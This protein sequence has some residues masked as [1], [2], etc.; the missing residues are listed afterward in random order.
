[1]SSLTTTPTQKNIVERPRLRG[2]MLEPG[3]PPLKNIRQSASHH[4]FY[5]A[6]QRNENASGEVLR[7]PGM[8]SDP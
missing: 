2:L 4:I 1:M 5:F 7:Q 8:A 6:R 3:G